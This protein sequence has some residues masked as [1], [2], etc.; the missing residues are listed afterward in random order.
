MR[1]AIAELPKYHVDELRSKR[2]RFAVIVCVRDEGERLH[3]QLKRMA[4]HVLPDFDVVISDAPSTDGSTDPARLQ[5]ALVSSLVSLVEPGGL[6]SS[7]RVAMAYALE[8]GYEGIVIMDGNNKDGPAALADFAAQLDA[9]MDYVQGSRF[10]PGGRA[11]NTPW[12]RELLIR[13]VHA[14]FFSII[15]KRRFSDSTNGFRAFSRRL[16]LD[17]RVASFRNVFDQYE[18]PYY[19]AW[20][21]CRYRF[22]TAE[23]PVTRSYPIGKPIPTKISGAKGYWRMLKP[24]L[25]LLL[26]RY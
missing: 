5:A 19:L 14:P 17:A 24:M 10:M 11:E 3:Q 18:L 15:C 1:G 26:R 8:A 21:A 23:I 13:F 4:P 6:S 20:A 7:L 16:L 25:M 9:G 12:C 22:K 2:G